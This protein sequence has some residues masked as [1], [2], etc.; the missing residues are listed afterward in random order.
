[1][2]NDR[3]E[4]H[5]QSGD[6]AMKLHNF[7]EAWECFQAALAC[8]PQS[9]YAL[10]KLGVI[11][12]RRTKF[13]EAITYFTKALEYDPMLAAAYN[14]M[15]NAHLELKRY[16][17]AKVY[18]EKALALNPDYA[19]AHHNLGVV[20]RR[21]GEF[22]KAIPKLKKGDRLQER[23]QRKEMTPKDKMIGLIGVAIIAAIIVIIMLL[24][25]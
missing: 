15:G 20:L 6:E 2:V 25:R 4:G 19:S 5:I 22:F 13:E 9:A 23:Q 10:N 3:Y 7:D 21:Q 14:N 12:C 8:N 1:M 18:Y 16:D 11:L 17:E 24:I